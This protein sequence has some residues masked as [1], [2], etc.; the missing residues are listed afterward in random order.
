MA[1]QSD[2]FQIL[3][4][5]RALFLRHLGALLQDSGLVSGNA[6]RAIQEGAG[7]YFD[8]MVSTNRR[9][10]FAEEASGLTS[11]RITLV[12]EDDL[13]LGIRLDNL[14]AKLFEATGG[15]LWKIH[16]RFVSLLRRPDLP[17]SDNP[18]G[19][20]GI[21]QGLQAM[22]AAAGASDIEQKLALLD[23]IEGYLAQ[24]L[25]ALYAEINDFLDRGG[26]E[27]AQPSIVGAQENPPAGR[28][29][30]NT[31]N[32]LLALQNTLLARLPVAPPTAA[33]MPE[34]AGGG[35]AASLL[36]QATI[37]R[38]LFRLNELDRQGTFRQDFRPG[39][40]PSN[41]SLIPEL[42]AGDGVANAAPK[43]LKSAQLGIPATAGEGLAIDTLALIF[44]AIFNDPA[45][46]DA[47]KATISSLQITLLKVAMKDTTLF[48]DSRHPARQVIDRMGQAVLG[49][50]ADVPARHPVCASLFEIAGQ[51]RSEQNI[52]NAAFTD[53][54]AKLDALIASRNAALATAVEPYLP[55]LRQVDRGDE[56]GIAARN[57]VDRIIER[58][59]PPA[60]RNFLNP[61]WRKVLQQVWLDHGPESSQ[62]AAH[63]TAIDD[64]LWTFQPK[65]D[66]EE[67]KT[68]ARRL[69]VILKLL[70]TGMEQVGVP[71]QA[72]EA[73][74][75]DCFKLQTQALRAT[76]NP[77][78]DGTLPE[79]APVGLHAKEG[80]PV[81]GRVQIGELTMTTLD[82]ADVQSSAA[83][84]LPAAIGDWLELQ[85]DAGKPLAA[86]LSYISPGT[87]RAMLLN[88]DLGLALAIHPVLL[89][90]RLRSGEAR[91]LTAASL[92][93][94][95]A[96]RALK[97][98]T[99]S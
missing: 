17:K 39:T 99:A 96:S 84:S 85:I 31:E 12:G 92:F 35:A 9:G 73:F 40:T 23:R 1:V 2:S 68:L 36:S 19:P 90:R 16:L 11:S 63:L 41:E 48:T 45:L 27:T 8:E 22:F 95:A 28:R 59:P 66:P 29:P 97:N 34:A 55:L 54:L 75:D 78:G 60:I 50:P 10:S 58:N 88:P 82:L 65:T 18:V 74:L 62:W 98:T 21:S 6:V 67:R 13:E 64:L 69:P 76:P 87:R 25:P 83:P 51:L 37:E 86:R 7:S 43:I 79:L 26:V 91:N 81:S 3:S 46:P 4:N 38:L 72:Q 93:D 44:E 71:A 32:S 53:A 15:G 57:A 89:D 77:A 5:C 14:S 56:A 70:K 24:N 61:S 94:D 33:V 20:K 42:F 49:L 47:L 52:S 30:Q 80:A